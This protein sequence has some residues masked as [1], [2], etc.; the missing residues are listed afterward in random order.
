MSDQETPEI[1]ELDAF[2]E[3]DMALS[4]VDMLARD[5][6]LTFGEREHELHLYLQ[7][8]QEEDGS[9]KLELLDKQDKPVKR[10]RFTVREEE[11]GNG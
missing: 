2:S 1:D 9:V 6:M 8:S 11:V 10:Y 5:F 4:L 7:P 3:R